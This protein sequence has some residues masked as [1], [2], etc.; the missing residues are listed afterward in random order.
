ML[1]KTSSFTA[2]LMNHVVKNEYQLFTN[3]NKVVHFRFGGQCWPGSSGGHV[4]M[5]FVICLAKI[6]LR[7]QAEERI[8]IFNQSK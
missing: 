1:S 6:P 2:F 7:R 3:F 4:S 5:A 8:Q